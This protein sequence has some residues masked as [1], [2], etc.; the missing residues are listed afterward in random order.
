MEQ[1]R[2]IRAALLKTCAVFALVLATAIGGLGFYTFFNN[3]GEQYQRYISDILTYSQYG[4][5]V[6]ELGK[7]IENKEWSQMLEREKQLLDDVKAT[8]K[9]TFIYIVKPLNNSEVDNMQNIVVGE[10]AD[11]VKK[12]C[13]MS[14]DTVKVISR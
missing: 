3:M 6:D 1:K 13:Q 5:D 7:D 14:D 12:Y 9:I 4:L 8:H 10:T 11:E 2:S